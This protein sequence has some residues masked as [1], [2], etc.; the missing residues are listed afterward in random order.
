M[1]LRCG[2]REPQACAGILRLYTARLVQVSRRVRLRL[3]AASFRV[4][5][6]TSRAVRLRLSRRGRRLIR[7]RGR[8]ATLA[9]A[10]A[11]DAAGNLGTARTRFTIVR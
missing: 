8:L 10:R 2:S 7:S 9:I 5:P 6:G 4:A 1:R 3:A 11:R